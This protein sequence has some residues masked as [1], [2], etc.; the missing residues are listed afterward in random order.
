MKTEK[1]TL[2]ESLAKESYEVRVS[3]DRSME[4]APFFKEKMKKAKKILSVS[5]LPKVH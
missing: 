1:L 2:M 5:G 4:N 3:N